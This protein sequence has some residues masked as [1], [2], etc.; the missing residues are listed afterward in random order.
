MKT[1]WRSVDDP[2]EHKGP[3]SLRVLVW[4]ERFG[5]RF[6]HYTPFYLGH[7]LESE[8]LWAMETISGAWKPTHWMPLPDPPVS[9][10]KE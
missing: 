2:P 4:S 8:M 7:K 9:P 3:H 10:G 1:E 6:G 5:V